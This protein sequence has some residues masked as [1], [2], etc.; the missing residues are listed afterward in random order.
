[1]RNNVLVRAVF[2]TKSARNDAETGKPEFFI[3]HK[4]GN[5]GRNDGVE[6]EDTEPLSFGL[7][8]TVFDEEMTDPFPSHAFFNGVAC[9]A[10]VPTPSDVV[11]VKNVQTKKNAIFF[12]DAAISLGRE[13]IPPRRKVERFFLWERHAVFH[14][15]VPNGDHIG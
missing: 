6:L 11:G 8:N 12:G 14:D 5:I 13:K 9:V 7:L 2:V 1:M 3:E 4:G 15:V 10:E